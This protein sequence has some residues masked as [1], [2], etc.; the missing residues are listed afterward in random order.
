MET[1]TGTFL[2]QVFTARHL[3]DKSLDRDGKRPLGGETWTESS[4]PAFHLIAESNWLA[5]SAVE[6]FFAWTE[7]IFIHVA[8]M[9]GRKSTATEVT[10]MPEA[11]WSVKFQSA[12]DLADSG[13]T[14]PIIPL[15]LREK[16]RWP[17][18]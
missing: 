4:F 5:I 1:K 15:D 16:P 6:A 10:E 9:T 8:L 11:D 13:A 17:M 2:S 12:L 7:H 14:Q 3:R 18:N